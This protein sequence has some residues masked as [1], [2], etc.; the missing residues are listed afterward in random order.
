M[1]VGGNGGARPRLAQELACD[2]TEEQAVQLVDKIMAYYKANAGT[3]KRLG[4]MIEKIGWDEFKQAIL[5][6]EA[7]SASSE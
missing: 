5:G 7:G 3:H 2:L 1:L 6:P 4:A